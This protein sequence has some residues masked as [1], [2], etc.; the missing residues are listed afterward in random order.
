MGEKIRNFTDLEAW[1]QAHQLALKIYAATEQF[2]KAEI[3]G[4]VS[5]MRRASISVASNIAEG[6]SRSTR[7]DKIR[8]YV[9]ASGSV[10]ELQCQLIISRDLLFLS[11]DQYSALHPLTVSTHKLLDG[12]TSSAETAIY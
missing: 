9:M 1:K 3:F 6:F 12:L 4:L 5:Q 2:P 8:F 10:T 11:S 7:E